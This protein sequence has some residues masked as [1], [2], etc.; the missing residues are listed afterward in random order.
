[1]NSPIVSICCTTYNHEKYIEETIEGFLAQ[2]VE[3]RFEIIIHDDASTD[4]TS[5]II[6][7]YA[8]K[9]PNLI[10]PILQ[11]ENQWSKGIRPSPTLVW[12]RAKGKY[13]ALCE[14]DDYWTDPLKLQKQVDLMEQNTELSICF[15]Y[16]NKVDK[17]DKLLKTYD[18]VDNNNVL[19]K[20]VYNDKKQETRTSSII[21]RI[22]MLDYS[23]IP[24]NANA[25]DLFLKLALL[26]KGDGYRIP[27]LMSSYRIHSGGVWSAERSIS[28]IRRRIADQKIKSKLYNR[29]LLFNF[30]LLSLYM[31][32]IK[33]QILQILKNK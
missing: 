33:Y 11:M 24:L 5:K 12:P 9:Y 6:Q 27:E 13:I 14:G 3:F 8:S 26:S 18:E 2:E 29:S 16:V 22:S 1:M 17:D 19:F 25:G 30:I 7:R 31:D 21:F 23:L 28:I 4:N 10:F 15:H 20:D 32:Q